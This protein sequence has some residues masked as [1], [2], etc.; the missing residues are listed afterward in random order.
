MD[1]GGWIE[2]PSAGSSA[3]C[4]GEWGTRWESADASFLW[5]THLTKLH[6]KDG[7]EWGQAEGG[8]RPP[9]FD[10]SSGERRVPLPLAY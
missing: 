3:V 1:R 2:F 9:V 10:R 5:A 7:H 8:Q 6:K 4:E